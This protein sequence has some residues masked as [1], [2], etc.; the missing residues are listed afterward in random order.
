MFLSQRLK[1][2]INL[3]LP[4]YA[5]SHGHDRMVKVKTWLLVKFVEKTQFEGVD[6]LGIRLTP[7]AHLHRRDK[8]CT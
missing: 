4:V 1:E 8:N 7:F 3:F 2:I 6:F 5:Q